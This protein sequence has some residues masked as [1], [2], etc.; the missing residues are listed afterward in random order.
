MRVHSLHREHSSSLSSVLYG[1]GLTENSIIKFDNIYMYVIM[2]YAYMSHNRVLVR[3]RSCCVVTYLLYLLEYLQYN[4][5][6]ILYTRR[7]Y[8]IIIYT[9]LV[10]YAYPDVFNI[11][12]R[13]IHLQT[14]CLLQFFLV[15]TYIIG[16]DSVFKF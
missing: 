15:G 14:W 11:T 6:I 2:L 9:A 3:T 5:Y 8:K 4:M 13:T 1:D 10:T 7:P 12:Y 16:N